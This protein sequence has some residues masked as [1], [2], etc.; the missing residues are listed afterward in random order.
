MVKIVADIGNTSLKMACFKDGELL[1]AMRVTPDREDEVEESFLKL[2]PYQPQQAYLGSVAGKNKWLE[3]NLKRA[4]IA[5][6]QITRKW[7]LPVKNKYLSPDTLGIDRI[8]NAAAAAALFPNK[9][10]VIVDAGTCIK[11]DFINKQNEYFGGSISPGI[12]MRFKAL[13]AFTGALPMLD[14]SE[15]VFLIGRNT[16]ES[17]ISG[18]INGALAEVNGILEQYLMTHKNLQ[19]IITGGDQVI[20][21]RNIKVSFLSEPWLTLRGLNEIQMAHEAA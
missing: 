13:H 6:T 17:M 4:G 7:T 8:A 16:E 11:F 3:Q 15:E 9:P 1:R 14:R 19:I 5:C 18:V 10:I 21:E 20:F 2:L 12:D